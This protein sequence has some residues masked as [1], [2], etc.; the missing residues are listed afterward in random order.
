MAPVLRDFPLPPALARRLREAAPAGCSGALPSPPVEVREAATVM[1]VADEPGGGVA[2]ITFRRRSTLAFAAGMLAFPGGAVEPQDHRVPGGGAHRPDRW[3]AAAVRETFEECGI[4]L[5][6]PGPGPGSGGPGS[7]PRAPDLLRSELAAGRIDLAGVLQATGMRWVPDLLRPWAHWV[8]PQFE[9]RRFDTRFFL[10]RLP[11]GQ[12]PGDFDG[13]AEPG[14]GGWT[15][16]REALR[17]HG[18]GELAMLPPT[19]VCLEELAAA[20]SVDALFTTPRRPRPVMPW[21]AT[22]AG[23]DGTEELVLRVD[24]DG[25]GGGDQP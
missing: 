23:P 8:T 1:V 6:E 24:L 17:R 21:P 7:A 9:A 25:L 16:A 14:H 15:S 11:T 20:P 19:Q 13:E 22:V 10:A 2:V 5:A 3:R 18:A 4:L 12:S